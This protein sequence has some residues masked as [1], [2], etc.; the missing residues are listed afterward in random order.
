MTILPKLIHTFNILPIKNPV[1]I[2]VETDQLMPK[3]GWKCERLRTAKTFFE[4][5]KKVGKLNTSQLQN[6]L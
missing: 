3:F 5:K 4:N 2:F 1:G 6:L